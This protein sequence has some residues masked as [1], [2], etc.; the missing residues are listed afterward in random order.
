MPSQNADPRG[1]IEI[2]LARRS[3]KMSSSL[4]TPAT[5]AGI[6]LFF[7]LTLISLTNYFP[8]LPGPSAAVASKVA[9]R[10]L[11]PNQ[12]KYFNLHTEARAGQ[13]KKPG[14]KIQPGS[15]PD[16][17]ALDLGFGSGVGR[18]NKCSRD[19]LALCVS[20]SGTQMVV[21]PLKVTAALKAFCVLHILLHFACKR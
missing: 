20:F 14:Y 2:V 7:L 17:G 13:D 18:V 1:G 10:A 19:K 15:I 9:M 16:S 5:P 11:L 21:C 6:L 4:A 8:R 12:R 3:C